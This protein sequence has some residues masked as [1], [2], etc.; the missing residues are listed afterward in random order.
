MSDSV[1]PHIPID[2][3]VWQRLDE[4]AKRLGFDSAEAYIR[5][6]AT[7]EADGRAI[8]FGEDDWGVRTREAI[9]R[10]NRRIEETMHDSVAG[11]LPF[12]N[13]R[14]LIKF[15]RHESSD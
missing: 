2:R 13:I 5:V 1:T 8:D 14:D 6:W 7:A 11:K 4:K 3:A 10:L 15:R 9:E 12:T